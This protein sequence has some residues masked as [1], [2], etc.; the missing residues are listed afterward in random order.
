M[1]C[2]IGNGRNFLIW[3]EAA[4]AFVPPWSDIVLYRIQD[5]L[6]ISEIS[7]NELVCL[8]AFVVQ[9]IFSLVISTVF[10]IYISL[11]LLFVYLIAHCFCSLK[12]EYCRVEKSLRQQT[13]QL[14]QPFVN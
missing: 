9:Y 4:K 12:A 13:K 14:F 3:H 8:I 6:Q 7:T 11:L 2:L 1:I 5:L 10:H